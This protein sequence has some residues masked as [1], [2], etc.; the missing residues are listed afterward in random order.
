MLIKASRM[1]AANNLVLVGFTLGKTRAAL[2]FCDSWSLSSRVLHRIL[3][4]NDLSLRGMLS[5]RGWTVLGG[6]NRQAEFSGWQEGL[7]CLRLL[8]EAK[9]V[10]FLNDTVTSH[11]HFSVFRK[12][13]LVAEF[14]SA[15]PSAA[16]GFVDRA[17]DAG[18]ALMLA[19][20]PA[21]SWISTYCFRLSEVTLRSLQYRIW[22]PKLVEAM[23]PGG[24][25]EST[26]FSNLVSPA[27]AA[28]L[29]WFL[30]APNGWHSSEA[31]TEESASRLTLKARCICSELVLSARCKALGCEL[32]DPFERRPQ[33]R[34]LDQQAVALRRFVDRVAGRTKLWPASR[35]CTDGEVPTSRKQ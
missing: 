16:V 29:R 18:D 25:D 27:L 13:A 12:H 23:V 28:S 1:H 14:E 22:D 4:L 35:T 9:P 34:R 17:T 8:G 7:E 20:M 30:F 10:V 3:V 11:R 32:R 5:T 21:D 24:S 6:S 31:L 19:G 26:F 2:E 15:P 33:L